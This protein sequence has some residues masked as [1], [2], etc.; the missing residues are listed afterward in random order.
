MTVTTGLQRPKVE[1]LSS[2]RQFSR[3][4]PRPL[5]LGSI[6]VEF[7]T[8]TIR[9]A[10]VKGFAHTVIRGAFQQDPGLL[11]TPERIRQFSSRRV[12]DR[13]MKQS[14]RVRWRW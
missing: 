4:S 10:K 14:R 3:R 8:V 12:Q 5:L 6:P 11:E 2:H 1:R 9:I 7:D 13:K